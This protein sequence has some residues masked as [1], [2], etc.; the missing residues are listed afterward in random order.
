MVFA[1]VAA[2][3]RD[4]HGLSVTGCVCPSHPSA[5]GSHPGQAD[6]CTAQPGAERGREQ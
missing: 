5:E 1:S 6:T 4:H 2:G 3:L